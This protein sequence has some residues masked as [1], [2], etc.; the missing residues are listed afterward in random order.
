MNPVDLIQDGPGESSMA[1]LAELRKALSIGYTQP[2]AGNDALRVESLDATLKL[3]TYQ[4][5]HARLWNQIPKDTAYSTIKYIGTTRAVHHP[6]TLVR[7]V[8]ADKVAQ[9]VTNGALWMIG[10]ANNALYNADESVNPLE[11]NGLPAQIVNGGGIVID[12]QGAAITP[13]KIEDGCRQVSE[14]FGVPMKLFSAP[15]VFSDFS[16]QY[17]PNQRFAA[18][19]VQPG[20]VGTPVTGYNST[21]GVVGFEPDVF[22]TQGAAPLAA[23]SSIKAPSAPTL[24]IGAPGADASPTLNVFLAGDAGNYRWQ[25]SAV[26]Q[27][28]ESAPSAVSASTAM[29]AGQSVALTITDGGGTFPA[30]GYRIYRTDKTGAAAGPFSSTTRI[31]RTSVAGVPQPTTVF[32]ER[33]TFRPFTYI[34]LMLDLNTQNLTFKQLAPMLKMDLAVISPAIRWMQLLYGT[35][36]VFA[37]K[38]QVLFRN[39]GVA[40]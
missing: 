3:L 1:E 36:I 11:F 14:N 38:R 22:I 39:I 10:K 4:S 34:G 19:G 8:P 30:T 2:V 40:P 25:V 9:E 12:M 18:P 7:S 33:N 35:P 17:A 32:T 28:G 21:F 24:A 23:A 20:I 31:A 13:A 27:Y 26:N 15:K 37:P 6:A 29:A 16:L 5:T